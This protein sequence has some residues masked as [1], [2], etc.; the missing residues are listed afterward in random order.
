MTWRGPKYPGDFPSLGYGIIKFLEEDFRPPAGPLKNE[1]LK[2]TPWQKE[3][4]VVGYKLVPDG[5]GGWRRQF[6]HI[7]EH[8][9]KGTGKSPKASMFCIV[10]LL[11]PTQFSHWSKDGEP[12]GMRNENAYI[13]IAGNSEEQAKRTTWRALSLMLKRSPYSHLNGGDVIVGKTKIEYGDN[14]IEYVASSADSA[15]GPEV[16]CGVFE[17]TQYWRQGN[18]GFLVAETGKE[19]VDKT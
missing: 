11:G 15:E 12:V 2:L 6:R 8:G 18:G 16:T 5:H 9:S 1:P 4:F 13:Q 7:A 10:E 19:N 14:V 17:E 3:D